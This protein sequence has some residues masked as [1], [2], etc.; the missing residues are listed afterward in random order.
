MPKEAYIFSDALTSSRGDTPKE[1][2]G[3]H[4]KP[5]ATILNR[6]FGSQV[7]CGT[8]DFIMFTSVDMVKGG[9]NLAI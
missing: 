7:V 1:G 6:V 5:G 8:I 4:S 2:V 3:R 9:A